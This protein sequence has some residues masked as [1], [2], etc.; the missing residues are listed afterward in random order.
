MERELDSASPA[1]A[2]AKAGAIALPAVALAEEGDIRSSLKPSTC[3]AG[4]INKKGNLDS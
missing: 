3:H 2:L 1:V 4:P